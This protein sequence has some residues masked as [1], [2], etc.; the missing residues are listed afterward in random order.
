MEL[1]KVETVEETVVEE[2]VEEETVEEVGVEEKEYILCCDSWG[3]DRI[4]KSNKGII[5]PYYSFTP[6]YFLDFDSDSSVI[7]NNILEDILV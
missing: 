7:E 6:K 4:C 2:T 1:I 3:C 5:I